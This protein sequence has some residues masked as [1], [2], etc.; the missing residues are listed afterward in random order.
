MF[1]HLLVDF[2]LFMI[3]LVFI[4]MILLVDFLMGLVMARSLIFPLLLIWLI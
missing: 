4:L 3:R 1:I 2:Q